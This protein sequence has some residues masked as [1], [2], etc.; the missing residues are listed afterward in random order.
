ML[1][2][3]GSISQVLGDADYVNSVLGSLP[4][5]NT[6]DPALQDA[7]RALEQMG[8]DD[9]DNKTSEEKKEDH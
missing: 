1:R 8:Q 7:V 4:G 3:H 5:V 2:A 9:T 6:N